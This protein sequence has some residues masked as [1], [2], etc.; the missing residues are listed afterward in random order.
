VRSRGWRGT[1]E[2][3]KTPPYEICHRESMTYTL[4]NTDNRGI[5]APLFSLNTISVGGR[6]G[7][8]GPLFVRT[9]RKGVMGGG[10]QGFLVWVRG[11]IGEGNPCPY[12]LVCLFSPK[13]PLPVRARWL[14]KAQGSVSMRGGVALWSLFCAKAI[15]IIALCGGRGRA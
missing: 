2:G 15:R 12:A 4:D 10:G 11:M 9:K 5:V 3:R 13:K 1:P 8:D 14:P 6:G 7:L